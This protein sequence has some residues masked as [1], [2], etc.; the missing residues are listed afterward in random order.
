MHKVYINMPSVTFAMK[1]EKILRK[2]HIYGLVVKTPSQFSS[3]G[4]SYSIIIN[5]NQLESAKTI[6]DK[7]NIQINDIRSD[8]E[9]Q[10]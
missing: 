7:N 10:L 6:L 9:V 4:C 1:S 3:H 5:S 8:Q 2:N